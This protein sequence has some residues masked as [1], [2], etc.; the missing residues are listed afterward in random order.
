MYPYFQTLGGEKDIDMVVPPKAPP[1]RGQVGETPFREVQTIRGS[2]GEGDVQGGQGDSGQIRNV[3]A[4]QETTIKSSLHWSS[5]Q[6]VQQCGWGRGNHA[7]RHGGCQEASSWFSSWFNRQVW[8]LMH[9][10]SWQKKIFETGTYEG[11]FCLIIR[12]RQCK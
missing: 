3:R 8:P 4:A 11:L 7:H 12:R 9:S 1:Q 5:T 6:Q 10:H 2:D